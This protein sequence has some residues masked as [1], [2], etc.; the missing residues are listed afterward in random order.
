MR[1]EEYDLLHSA[2]AYQRD[3]FAAPFVA[4]RN[5]GFM[6]NIRGCE[7]TTSYTN[8][9]SLRA[10]RPSRSRGRRSEAISLISW[11]N[12]CYEVKLFVAQRR[13]DSTS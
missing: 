3:C 6:L 9:P 5:D 8:Y 4:A 10:S 7:A 2:L 12:A 1:N 13:K 11:V